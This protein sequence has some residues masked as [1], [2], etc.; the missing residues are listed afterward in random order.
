MRVLSRQDTRLSSPTLWLVDMQHR[1]TLTLALLKPDL[2]SHALHHDRVLKLLQREQF[3]IAKEAVVSWDRGT[4]EHFYREH[5]GRFF[6]Q[7]LVEFMSS[8][9]KFHALVLGHRTEDAVRK[10]RS[11]L[12]P[13]KCY[14]ARGGSEE[15]GSIRA[16]YGLSDTRNA[17]HGSDSLHSFEREVAFVFPGWDY[18][19]WAD[20][21]NDW[22]VLF[23]V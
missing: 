17:G 16:L 9:E 4:A 8:G 18:K 5:Q 2:Y 3:I 14:Q 1:L 7:R 11:M 20:S 21:Q 13:T 19:K 22:F 15:R 12:G 23:V 6:Q 10:W